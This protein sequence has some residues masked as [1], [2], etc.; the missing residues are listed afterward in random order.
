MLNTDITIS[1]SSQPIVMVDDEALDR[2][3]VQRYLGRSRLENPFLGFEGGEDFLA[4]LD[5]AETG[6]EPIPALVLLDIN[7]PRMNGFEVLAAVRNIERF[8][9]VPIITM[10]TSSTDQRD[11]DRTSEMGANEYMVKP[12]RPREYQDFF[13][14]LA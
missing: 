6:S 10:L 3:S 13:D 14:S 4:Y 2:E 8:R 5:D 9:H 1:D 7:M 12:Y 11:I